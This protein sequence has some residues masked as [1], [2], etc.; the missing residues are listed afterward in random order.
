MCGRFSLASSVEKVNKQMGLSEKQPLQASY[1]IAPTHHAYLL[2]NE[3]PNQL[4]RFMWGLIPHWAR[5]ARMGSNLINARSEGISGKPSFRMPIRKKRCL[6]LADGF[7]EWRRDGR[8]RIPYR[9]TT[10]DASLLVMAGVWDIW[11]A[12]N[13]NDVHTFSIIT[14]PPNKEMSSVH[15][16]MPV[17]FQDKAMQQEWLA[18]QKIE[19]ILSMLRTPEDDLLNIYPVSQKVNKPDYN[20]PDLYTRQDLPP[21]LFG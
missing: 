21:T 1:N 15:N 7:Y 3:S 11:K 16:R 19:S 2:T 9:I 13:G 12:P 20:Q 10:K 5:D 14:T 4:Q 18:D 17:L 8:N 6:V